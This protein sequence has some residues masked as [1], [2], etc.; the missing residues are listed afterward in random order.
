MSIAIIASRSLAGGLSAAGGTLVRAKAP[1][2]ISFAGGGTDLPHYYEKFQGAV[3]SSTINRYAH[4]TIYPRTD[5]E[6]EIRSLDLGHT[7]RYSMREQPVYDGVMDLAK[8]AIHRVG[9]NIGMDLDVRMEA[10]RGSGLGGS[11]ALTAAVLGAVASLNGHSYSLY[12]L[13][14]LNYTIERT[15]LAITGGKQDQYATTFGGFNL[16]EFRRDR[17][18][19][20]PLRVDPAVLND[21]EAHLLLCYTGKVRPNLGLVGDQIKYFNEGR[22]E[23]V[24]GMHRLYE[25]VFEMKEAL[26]T[27]NLERFG[28]MLHEA[29]MNKKRM[30]P[31][32]SEGT[33]ADALYEAALKHGTIGGKLLGAGGGGYLLL[34][35]ETGKQL[36]VRHA[37]EEM[38][39]QF[40]DFS[41]DGCGLQVWRSCSR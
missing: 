5:H 17:V 38:G 9:V 10:P 7:V 2:R 23:T 25:M 41:F 40:A 27:G 37:L 30:N 13:A 36:A 39:G 28:I 16:L 15:D 1:L 35:C 22:K 20:T 33:P 14:E 31:R 19:V 3:L 4:V 29:Y 26:L 34:Y 6:I 21:L 18:V 32:V 12:D 24:D 11:S 8:A